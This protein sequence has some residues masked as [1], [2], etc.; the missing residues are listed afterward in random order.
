MAWIRT[1]P[2]N[3]A[4][5]LLKEAYDWQ[6]AKLGEP[7]EYT[8]LA[9]LYPELVYERLRLY[10]TVEGCP[11]ELSQVERQMAALATSVLNDTPHCASGLRLKLESLGV[12]PALLDAIWE[13]PR[14]A[15]SG[16]ARLDAILA[17]AVK[18]TLEPGRMVPED[19]DALRGQDLSDLDILD[20]NNMVGYYC[21]TNRVSNGL[22]L[23]TTMTTVRQATLA[24]PQ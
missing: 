8:M 21:Y 16:D 2:W 5:G 3:E 1:V 20:L 10:K 13:D 18:L 6:A 22:G 19:V 9:S 15:R 23:K 12:D 14:T 4:T 17:Y 7:A 11:S 24:L